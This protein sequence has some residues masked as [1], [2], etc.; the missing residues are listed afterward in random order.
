MPKLLCKCGEVLSY[1]A[2]PC[3]VEW[4]LLSDVK[5]DTFSGQIDAEAI[6]RATDMMLRCPR[7]DRL[8]I[9]WN[10]Q[11][12]PTEYLRSPES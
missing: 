4:R 8:W 5:F 2:I 10:G 1:G 12:V 3:P 6:Y 9:F 7:C 11:E